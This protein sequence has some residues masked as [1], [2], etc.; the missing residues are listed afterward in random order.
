MKEIRKYFR[1]PYWVVI[2]PQ[3]IGMKLYILCYDDNNNGGKEK[4]LGYGSTRTEAL[5]MAKKYVE[6][7][8]AKNTKTMR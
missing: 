1:D 3:F 7:A 8:L 2:R 4:M 5:K 6:K